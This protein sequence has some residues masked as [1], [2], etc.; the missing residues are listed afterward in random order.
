MGLWTVSGHRTSLG[1]QR[2]FLEAEQCPESCQGTTGCS[3]EPGREPPPL[4]KQG[5]PKQGQPHAGVPQ[6]LA[7]TWPVPVPHSRKLH[8]LLLACGTAWHRVTQRGT[9]LLGLHEAQRQAASPSCL[10]AS[11]SSGSSPCQGGGGRVHAR[12]EC[13]GHWGTERV[14]GTNLQPWED[15]NPC[16]CA[17]QQPPHCPPCAM[18]LLALLLLL[19]LCCLWARLVSAGECGMDMGWERD[20]RGMNTGWGWDGCEMDMGSQ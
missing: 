18:R 4:P 11:L 19:G 5:W 2:L 14:S 16:S 8:W 12:T 1:S 3:T 6:P 10:P 7:D 13:A 9:A 20:E 15:L 17:G